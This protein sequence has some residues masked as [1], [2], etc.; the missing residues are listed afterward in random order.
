MYSSSLQLFSALRS[1]NRS[2]T[3]N[4]YCDLRVIV[5]STLHFKYSIRASQ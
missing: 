1:C 3:K 5:T 4:I 2:R